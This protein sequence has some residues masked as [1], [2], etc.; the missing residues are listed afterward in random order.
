MK[1]NKSSILK[2]G[3]CNMKKIVLITILA[4]LFPFCAMAMEPNSG[5]G[6]ANADWEVEGESHPIIGDTCGT[7]GYLSYIGYR[8][9]YE[10]IC[11]GSNYTTI[12]GSVTDYL[13]DGKSVRVKME[14]SEGNYYSSYTKRIGVP[15]SFSRTCTGRTMRVSL[16]TAKSK[17]GS[18]SE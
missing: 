3:K 7:H 10:L 8:A 14:C 4:I 9:S 2:K 6:D 11:N 15:M 1:L 18:G 13:A 17:I 5:C 16:V 12:N